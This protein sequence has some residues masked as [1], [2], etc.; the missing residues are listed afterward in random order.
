MD[1][2]ENRLDMFLSTAGFGGLEWKWGYDSNLY[3][4]S[5]DAC[6]GDMRK[7]LKAANLTQNKENDELMAGLD[8]LRGRTY[9]IDNEIW[10]VALR[11]LSAEKV[12]VSRYWTFS[13]CREGHS[14]FMWKNYSQK[15]GKKGPGKPCVM[16]LDGKKIYERVKELI[17][18]DLKCGYSPDG[19]LHFFLPCF[20]LPHDKDRVK[21]L[22]DFVTGSDYYGCLC[23]RPKRDGR[24]KDDGK[25]IL[26]KDLSV[27]FALM[28]KNGDK[29][30]AEQETRLIMVGNRPTTEK[31]RSVGLGFDPVV[32]IRHSL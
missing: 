17:S 28:I 5:R 11:E 29:Y 6:L 4:Y 14:E 25:L 8:Y 12:D 13:L 18:E 15:N 9:S 27:M 20:Y 10:D 16:T 31:R 24:L 19:C 30:R 3:H 1:C 2:I 32:S 21:L 23:N 7:D 26:A 22:A